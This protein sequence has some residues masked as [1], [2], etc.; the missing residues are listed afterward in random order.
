MGDYYAVLSWRD[1]NEIIDK[2]PQ[3]V[4]WENQFIYSRQLSNGAYI[5]TKLSV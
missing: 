2:F 5:E 1:F 4:A 3:Y